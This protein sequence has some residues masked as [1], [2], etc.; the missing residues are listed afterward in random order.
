MIF[1]IQINIIR[2][3]HICFLNTFDLLLSFSYFVFNKLQKIQFFFTFPKLIGTFPQ[4]SPGS[5]P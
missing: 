2:Y 5:I 3:Y 4:C 1:Y